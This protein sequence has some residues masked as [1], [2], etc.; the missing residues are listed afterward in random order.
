M[1][2]SWMGV[3]YYTH[4]YLCIYHFRLNFEYM[5]Y[6]CFG[7]SPHF[8]IQYTVILLYS[9]WLQT[10]SLL[11]WGEYCFLL[12]FRISRKMFPSFLL[13]FLSLLP[14][15]KEHHKLRYE[16]TFSHYHMFFTLLFQKQ[17]GNDNEQLFF[18][19]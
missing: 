15:S 12:V 7:T 17:I 2:I 4:M 13:T 6:V 16:F 8:T 9:T 5:M 18:Y 14:F 10:N 3:K 11:V 19:F 1:E